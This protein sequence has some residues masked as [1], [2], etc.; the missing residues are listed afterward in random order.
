MLTLLG[1]EQRRYGDEA[2]LTVANPRPAAVD[3]SFF[4]KGTM[5][6]K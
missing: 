1:D 2:P 6:K 3:E 5:P 4:R